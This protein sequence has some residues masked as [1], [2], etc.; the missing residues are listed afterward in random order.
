MKWT[1]NYYSQKVIDGIM[2]WPVK[3]QSKYLRTVDLLETYG[4]EL[5]GTS[6]TKAMGD[7]LFEI[8]IKAQ[9][10]IGR[11]FFCYRC[12]HEIL[13]LHAFIKKTQKTPT[14]ELDLALQRLS[15]VKKWKN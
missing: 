9:E 3:L 7:G 15:E 10:G 6:L 12:G 13:I 14:K 8:R 1:V 2:R 4:V 5:G 11:A